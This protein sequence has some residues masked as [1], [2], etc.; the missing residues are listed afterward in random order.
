MNH[1]FISRVQ[2]IMLLEGS[3]VTTCLPHFKKE[4]KINLII[5]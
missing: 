3:S 5:F 1:F 2:L 4:E